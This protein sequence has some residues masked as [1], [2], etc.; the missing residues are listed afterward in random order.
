MFNH[1][2]ETEK[3]PDTLEQALIT[4]LLKPGKDPLLCGSYRPISLLNTSY[5]ILVKLIAL[6]LD[7]VLPDL[8]DQTGFVRN[9][10]SPDNIRR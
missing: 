6:R 5:N 1:A 4:V 8:V 10:S 9:R 7:K 3:F 2:I